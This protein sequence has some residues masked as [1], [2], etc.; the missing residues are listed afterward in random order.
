MAEQTIEKVLLNTIHRD[1][2]AIQLPF[3]LDEQL[4]NIE[5]PYNRLPAMNHFVGPLMYSQHPDSLWQIAVC[6]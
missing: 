2:P 1:D 3:A 4:K 5:I 6:F